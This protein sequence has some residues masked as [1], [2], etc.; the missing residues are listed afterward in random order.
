MR[1]VQENLQISELL[2]PNVKESVED[3][4]KKYPKR[5]L[6]SSQ[7]VVR[8]APSPTGFLHLG[9]VFT[10]LIGRKLADQSNGVCILRIEDT[11]KKREVQDGI[12]LIIDGLE[13]F[14]IKFDESVR[15]G[16]YGP[17]IQSERLDIYHVFAK[18]LVSIGGAYPCFA[19]E[20]ELG[21][22]RNKQ[23]ESGVRTGYYGKWAK[24]RDADLERY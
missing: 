9:S 16:K 4:Y 24:W 1:T 15:G 7:L 13:G 23:S 20:E 10:S 12:D 2:F 18:Y 11:D 3:M 17:Y 6:E 21:D 19:S 14:G 5:K 8:F 22:I